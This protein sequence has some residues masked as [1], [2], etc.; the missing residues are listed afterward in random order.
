MIITFADKNL[1]KNANNYK[2]AVKKM[3]TKRA[4][5]YQ[6]RLDDMAAA[7]SF[8]DFEFLPGRFHQLTGNLKDKWACDLDHPYR[9]IFEPLEVPIPKDKE[10]KQILIEIKSLEI[11][12]VTDYHKEG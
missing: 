4:K 11:I 5:L 7:Q 12:E 3:G 1:R 9:L 6:R 8:A 2:L 10:G